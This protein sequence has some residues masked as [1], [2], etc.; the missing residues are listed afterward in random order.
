VLNRQVIWATGLRTYCKFLYKETDKHWGDHWHR[1]G[2][3]LECDPLQF[4]SHQPR[5]CCANP[6][7]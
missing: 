5:C 6:G 7:V 2:W 4:A 1:S 3:V